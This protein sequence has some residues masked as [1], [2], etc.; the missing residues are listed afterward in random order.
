MVACRVPVVAPAAANGEWYAVT[1]SRLSEARRKIP[2]T[3][4][5][6]ATFV[7]QEPAIACVFT[8]R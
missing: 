3:V 4:L 2:M 1:T 7:F 8:V 5:M 6:A